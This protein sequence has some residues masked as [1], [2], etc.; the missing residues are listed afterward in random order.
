MAEIWSGYEEENVRY[1]VVFVTC[2]DKDEAM[3]IAE[4]LVT[5][6]LAACANVIEPAVSI[7]MWK[8][9]IERS[10]EAFMIIKTQIDA[11]PELVTRIK[12]LHSYDVPEIIALPIMGGN[13]AYLKWIDEVTSDYLLE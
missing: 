2:K 10:I 3:S 7:Y 13:P 9:K 8:G 5:E 11:F 12:E 4:V 6:K 1:L